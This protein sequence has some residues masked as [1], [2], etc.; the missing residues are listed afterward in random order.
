MKR[1][2][3]LFGILTITC[4]LAVCG[5]S[6]VYTIPF[7][8]GTATDWT[9]TGGGAIRAT[10]YVAS[11]GVPAIPCITMTS[12]SGST[13]SFVPGGSVANFDGFWVA[14]FTFSLPSNATGVSL[15][16][17]NFYVDDRAVLTLNGQIIDAAGLTYFGQLN[18]VG[19]MVFT[20]GGPLQPYSSFKMSDETASG[21]VTSGFN[22]GG[23]NTLEAI[24]NNTDS[25]VYGPDRDISPTDGTFLG[26]SGTFSY[27]VVPEPSSALIFGFGLASM[28][29]LCRRARPN[30]RDAVLSGMFLFVCLALSATFLCGCGKKAE[31]QS[32]AQQTSSA[33]E[34]VKEFN[35]P[36]QDGQYPEAGIAVTDENSAESEAAHE[37][38]LL[39]YYKKV[40]F[41]REDRVLLKNSSDKNPQYGRVQRFKVSGLRA[42]EEKKL[43][44]TAKNA[45]TTGLGKQSEI[46]GMMGPLAKR[47]TAQNLTDEDATAVL[48]GAPNLPKLAPDSDL[49]ILN[50]QVNS[51]FDK[52][53]DIEQRPIAYVLF[54]KDNLSKGI[55]LS[56]NDIEHDLMPALTKGLELA[57]N[58]DP[59]LD[60]NE[61]DIRF[62]RQFRDGKTHFESCSAVGWALFYNAGPTGQGFVTLS[63]S[64]DIFVLI[65]P[66]TPLHKWLSSAKYRTNVVSMAVERVAS[67]RSPFIG[68]W[69]AHDGTAFIPN[70]AILKIESDGTFK[71]NSGGQ[72]ISGTYVVAQR[73]GVVGDLITLTTDGGNQ[74]DYSGLTSG[75]IHLGKFTDY[76]LKRE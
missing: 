31:T 40:D 52:H 22:L 44:V 24:I 35:F 42:T 4:G 43:G 59:T 70:N 36:N 34:P 7:D 41:V 71:F 39:K 53:G 60:A 33:K 25:G 5:Y 46:M 21:V 67:T 29:F 10:P 68:T 63:T 32:A 51:A 55:A 65:E 50:N 18:S 12:D 73:P 75:V 19:S 17:W 66:E 58:A 56:E 16:Y 61:R 8:T 13:G 9:V 30:K 3:S 47:L 57:A 37:L 1:T 23:V 54:N 72:S 2:K 45:P 64:P 28:V 62:F 14:D 15:N 38:E 69:K 6:Q 48:Q 76:D 26:L 49:R 27:S 20:D 11:F 74:S